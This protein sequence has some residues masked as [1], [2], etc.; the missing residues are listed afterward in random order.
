MGLHSW[1]QS[2]WGTK[3]TTP[4]RNAHRDAITP[5]SSE[6]TADFQTPPPLTIS[7]PG[8][9]LRY[10]VQSTRGN[11]RPRNEDNFYVPGRPSL[12]NISTTGSTP[13]SPITSAHP[14]D[15]SLPLFIVADGMGGQL[16]GEKASQLAVELVPAY[17]SQQLATTHD[18]DAIRSA[19]IQA[20]D[21]ANEELLS[22]ST[23]Q[24]ELANMGTT[25]A[26]ALFANRHAFVTG[27]G[28]SRV[29][30]LTS[31]G[32][33]QLTRDHSLAHA[34]GEVGTIS[35][36]E[37]ETHKFKNILYLFLGSRDVHERPEPVH[38][39]EIASGDLFLLASDGLTGVVRDDAILE[40]LR[41][42]DDPQR[43]AQLLVNCAL[44]NKSKDNVTV[45]VVRVI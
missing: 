2:L 16:A 43:A 30:H 8:F 1:W 34:L 11:V 19:I 28:D 6:Q 27:L 12:Q 31:N 23:L 15:P 24:P 41:S 3:R 38:I 32:L 22:Q 9:E 42:T 40:I 13:A 7:I 44:D 39:V 4:S 20:I 14:I 36:A 26:L 35:P 17:L 29:Y 37:V 21:K 18:D 45:V 10:G 5:H 33:R 25:I